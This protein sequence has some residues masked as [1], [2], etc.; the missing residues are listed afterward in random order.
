M[1]CILCRFGN[2]VK[3]NFGSESI[4]EMEKTNKKKSKLVLL[5]LQQQQQT[6]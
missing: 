2:L 1:S 4:K 5:L 6:Q 3:S